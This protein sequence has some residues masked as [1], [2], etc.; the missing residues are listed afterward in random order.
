MKE[1]SSMV[2]ATTG[3][4]LRKLLAS[5]EGLQ[6]GIFHCANSL[7]SRRQHTAEQLNTIGLRLLAFAVDPLEKIGRSSQV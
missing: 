7:L 3:D 5:G 4:G 2:A 1:S 6:E